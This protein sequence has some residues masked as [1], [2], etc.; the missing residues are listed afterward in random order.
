MKKSSN[1]SLTQ[2]RRVSIDSQILYL[3]GMGNVNGNVSCGMK[4]VVTMRPRSL[5]LF[6]GFRVWNTPPTM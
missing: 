4:S 6:E 5:F 3:S 1:E 2:G